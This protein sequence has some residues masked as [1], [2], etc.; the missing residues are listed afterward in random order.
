MSDIKFSGSTC[1]KWTSGRANVCLNQFTV[2]K[3]RLKVV[4]RKKTFFQDRFAVRQMQMRR[5]IGTYL[6]SSA[7]DGNLYWSSR[8]KSRAIKL[9]YVHIQIGWRAGRGGDIGIRD[10]RDK[11]RILDDT[12]VYLIILEDALVYLIILEDTLVYLI[13][14][15]DTLVYFIILGDN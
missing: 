13:I 5:P 4:S 15:E 3:R 2:V 1:S 12:L 10:L 7:M 8:D 11:G 9:D 14:L 6:F